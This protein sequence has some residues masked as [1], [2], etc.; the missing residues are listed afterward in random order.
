[1][2]RFAPILEAPRDVGSR[3]AKAARPQLNC[4]A[5]LPLHVFCVWFRAYMYSFF[6]FC[7]S[8]LRCGV[9]SLLSLQDDTALTR[10]KVRCTLR[11]HAAIIRSYNKRTID[12]FF[13]LL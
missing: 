10:P 3:S 8:C 11:F 1:M 2:R 12:I 9:P 6:V 4:R 5:A 13:S 7:V